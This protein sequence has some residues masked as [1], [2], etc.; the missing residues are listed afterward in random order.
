MGYTLFPEG[1]D[2]YHIQQHSHQKDL[3]LCLSLYYY[4]KDIVELKENRNKKL[5]VFMVFVIWQSIPLTSLF[6]DFS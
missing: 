6:F 4:G 5:T 1:T 2:I 3:N